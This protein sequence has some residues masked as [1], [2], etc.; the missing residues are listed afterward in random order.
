M[1]IYKNVN[2]KYIYEKW[3]SPKHTKLLNWAHRYVDKHTTQ[4]IDHAIYSTI[5]EWNSAKMAC[6]CEGFH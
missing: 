6:N 4:N 5:K 1:I 3:V 2:K